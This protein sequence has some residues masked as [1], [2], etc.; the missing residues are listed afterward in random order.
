MTTI[1]S[2]LASNPRH[3]EIIDDFMPNYSEFVEQGR[4]WA[5]TLAS[6]R[7]YSGGRTIEQGQSPVF[8]QLETAVKALM[9]KDSRT[10]VDVHI[11]VIMASDALSPFSEHVHRDDTQT[12]Q[13]GYTYS[14]HYLGLP[15]AGG[16]VFYSD[17]RASKELARVEFQP[18]RLVIWRAS[19]PHTGYAHTDQPDQSRR[20]LLVMPVRLVASQPGQ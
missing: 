3:I 16:T 5:D 9:Y 20:V 15:G 11:R 10:L 18:N 1:F 4:A 14:Y 2:R 7:T 19:W 17:L 12:E 8:D 13:W 6:F